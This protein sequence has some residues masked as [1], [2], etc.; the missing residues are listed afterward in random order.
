MNYGKKIRGFVLLT[1]AGGL[2]YSYMHCPALPCDSESYN[3]VHY[4]YMYI[5]QI[6]FPRCFLKRDC[7]FNRAQEGELIDYEHQRLV[8]YSV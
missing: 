4:I 8:Y 1:N 3:Y 2:V 6:S 7:T 5:I